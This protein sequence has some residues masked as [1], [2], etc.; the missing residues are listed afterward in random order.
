M[1]PTAFVINSSTGPIVNETAL[2]DALHSRRIAGAGLGVY[3]H[4]PLAADNPLRSM[5]NTV[6]TPHVGGRT[7]ENFL[8][9]YADCM[10]GVKDWLDGAPV[11]VL[12]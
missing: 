8:A 9:R 1:K 7:R 12:S 10:Q 5:S 2:I 4:E 3:D 11:R 6:L